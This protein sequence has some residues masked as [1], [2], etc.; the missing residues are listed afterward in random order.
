MCEA[1]H[2]FGFFVPE[3]A[4]SLPNTKFLLMIREPVET[5]ISRFVNLSFFGELLPL[6]KPEIAARL[7]V[8]YHHDFN[9]FRI[10]PSHHGFTKPYQFFLF[11]LVHTTR[12]TFSDL[13][14]LNDNRFKVIHTLRMPDHVRNLLNWIDSEFP[15]DYD[16][17]HNKSTVRTDSVYA[18]SDRSDLIEYAK[19]LFLPHRQEIETEFLLAATGRALSET[20]LPEFLSNPVEFIRDIHAKNLNIV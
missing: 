6:L 3:L 12:M 16:S 14:K 17:A 18:K 2:R 9:A 4:K 10:K 8:T 7:E 5:L 11:D 19:E 1:N 15:W 20:V 13:F